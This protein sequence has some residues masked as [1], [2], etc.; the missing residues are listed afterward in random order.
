MADRLLPPLP[1][2]VCQRTMRLKQNNSICERGG[3]TFVDVVVSVLIIGI[4]AAVAGP[5]FAATLHRT[6]ADSAA[7]RIAADLSYARKS[8]ISQSATVTVEFLTAS[9]EYLIPALPDLN[10]P[11]EPYQIALNASPYDAVLVTAELGGDADVQFD[12]FGNPDSGGVITVAAGGFQQTVTID[13]DSG[14]ASI[15]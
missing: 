10:A 14:R 7:E 5:K 3:F 13:P 15:P 11:N 6:R 12:R 1:R 4:L 2:Q 8:A 9:D